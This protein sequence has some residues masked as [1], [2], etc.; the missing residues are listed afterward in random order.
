MKNLIQKPVSILIQAFFA[1][2]L[3]TG[4]AQAGG[5][6]DPLLASL[7]VDNLEISNQEN[8][9]TGWAASAWVGKDWHKLYLKSEGESVQGQNESENQL[10][11][12]TPV[13]KFWDLQLGLAY[14]TAPEANQTW[15]A[16]GLQG[17]APYFFETNALLLANS[18][19]LGIRLESEYEALFT[20]KLILTPSIALSAYS[21]DNEKM[22]TGSGLSNL[23]IGLRLRYEITRKFAPYI[24]L[25]YNQFFGTTA[26][27][28][29]AEGGKEQETSLVAGVRFWF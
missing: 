23:N 13:E 11:Y 26:D 7:I 17:L 3:I 21:F 14:D 22:G 10:L 6:R 20:Q 18:D 5:E 24:G 8:N 9:P 27:Y 29:K 19:G 2:T 4:I 16:I 15:A 12:S 1:T 25:T 28:V